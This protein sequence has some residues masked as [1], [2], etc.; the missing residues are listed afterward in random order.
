MSHRKNKLG[1]VEDI[2]SGNFGKIVG[3]LKNSVTFG[4]LISIIRF[5]V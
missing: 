3:R 1:C 2:I 5:Y 4:L